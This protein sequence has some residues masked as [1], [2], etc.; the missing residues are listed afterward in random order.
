MRLSLPILSTVSL[1]LLVVMGCGDGSEPSG[2]AT[3]TE[4]AGGSSTSSQVSGTGGGGG[5]ASSSTGTAGGGGASMGTGGGGPEPTRLGLHFTQEELV[6]LQAR[7][8]SGP[9]K[10][11][12]DAFPNS[13]G[14]WDR[15]AK[16]AS[17]FM[18]NP[19]TE[20]WSNLPPVV[21]TSVCNMAGYECE[22]AGKGE[23]VRDAAFYALIKNDEAMRKQ[24][25]KTLLTQI[26]TTGPDGKPAVDFTTSR[27]PSC[28]VLDNNPGFVIAEYLLRV[29]FAYDYVKE[30]A[31]PA[32][33]ATILKWFTDA[34][35]YLRRAVDYDRNQYFVD[36]SAG[37]DV[38]SAN[39]QKRFTT[40]P[41]FTTPR[42]THLYGPGVAREGLI[43]NNRAAGNMRF[44][45]HVGVLVN[46]R[47]LIQSAKLFFREWI[48]YGV[49]P[50]GVITEGVRWTD[51]SPERG[52]EYAASNLGHMID[53]AD[54]LARAGEP[55]LF[56]YTSSAGANGTEGGPKNLLLAMMTY[57]GYIDGTGPKRYGTDKPALDGNFDYLID[58]YLNIDS[59]NPGKWS[60]RDVWFT[61][62][63][64]F[65]KSAYITG[66]YTRKGPGLKGYPAANKIASA[67]PHAPW[68]GVGDTHPSKLF[69]FGLTEGTVW[70]YP[71]PIA[72]PANPPYDKKTCADVP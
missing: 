62:A 64:T 55:D 58:G 67:G 22:P 52:L 24:V 51:E 21:T 69:Q 68:G 5:A 14:E 19:S 26:A 70:P 15:I 46:D 23:H 41:Y 29:L 71:T 3:S 10:S 35:H 61:E 2:G 32:E 20:L 27:W 16:N 6:I 65:F 4:G 37:D 50:H 1:G 42:V 33:R 25:I 63:N 59:Y 39:G 8:A 48:R 28:K 66:V 57:E 31:T 34:A 12:G 38:L 45:G 47:Q 9:F 17:D 43:V 72:L 53:T 60:L 36:R 18:A 7:A 11:A 40:D 54:V 44:V 30:A 56:L 49:Y 13:P